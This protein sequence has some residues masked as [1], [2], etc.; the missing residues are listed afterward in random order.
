[1]SRR[2]SRRSRASRASRPSRSSQEEALHGLGLEAEVFEY[3]RREFNTLGQGHP[4]PVPL[5]RPRRPSLAAAGD[6][7]TTDGRTNQ[8]PDANASE[9]TAGEENPE[10]PTLFAAAPTPPRMA[11]AVYY[12]P[13]ILGR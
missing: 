6:P 8:E 11:L 12:I 7:S 3:V 4:L 9:E 1:M 5:N 2:P 10:I 13:I